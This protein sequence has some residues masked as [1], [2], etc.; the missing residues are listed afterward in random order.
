ME[1]GKRSSPAGSRD[2][3]SAN[4]FPSKPAAPAE[5]AQSSPGGGG[6]GGVKEHGN[7]VCFKVDGGGAEEPVVGFEDAEGPRRQYG[8]MQR[9]FTSMLQPGVNKFSLRMFGSQKAVEKEQERVKTAGFW[10]IHPYSDFRFYWDLIMLIM[11]VGN[12]VIIPVGIT[13]F[14]EQTTTPWIIFNVAS[15]TVFLLDLIMNFRT[16]TVNEDSSEIILD[17]K[18]IKMN[19]LK[20]W[21]VVDFIS[22]IPVDYIFLIV[23]KGM[24][25]E[26]YKTARAL[27]I[28]RFTKILSLLRLL[29]LSRLIRYIHQ[30]EEIFHMT[31]DLASAVVRIFNLIGMMLLLCHWDGCLQFLVPLLQDFPPD[32][33]V[34]LN[35]MVNDSWG[36]Q[37]SYALFKAMSHMLCIG[38]GARAPVSM[39]DL[40]I[41]MLSMIVGATCYAMFVGH[42]TALIQSLDSSRRQYQ[43]KYK[44]VEQYMSF[45][46]LPAEMRQK[47]HDYYE[48]RYQGKIFDEENILNELNDPLREE[49]VNFNCRKLVATMPLFANA[50]PNFVTAMLSKL[51]FEVFQP[52]DY[53][54]REGAV[55]KKMYF[56]QHG[57]AGVITKSNK[58]LKLTDGSYFGEICLL[59]KGRRTASVRADTYCRLYSLS[60]D[61]FNEVLEE[62]PMMRRAFET[63]AIDRLDRIGK[64]N[65]ILL[66]K[67]QKD[68]NT[69][70]FNN[71]ENEIL[72]QIVKHDREMVQ[73]IAPVSLQQMPALNSSTSASSSR[74]RTQSPPV[75]TASSLSHGNLHSPS[76]STQTPQQAVILSPCSY[77][78]AV[79]SPPIQS[80]LAGRTFQYA[81][82]T[83]SQLSLMQQ[84]PQA[85]QQPPRAT[86][87]NE[88]HKSTQALHN[89]TLTREVRPLS[90]SQPS[91]PH[92][93]STLIARPHPTVGES[94]ASLPQPTPGP[95]V[96]P[97]SRATVPQ[98]VSLFRQMSSGAIPPNR[99]AAP[100]PAPLQRDSSTVLSTEPEGDKPRFASN[101]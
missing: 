14:T 25:S 41:T 42:A 85:P 45:H 97:A 87:K 2:D 48:H 81:S 50:D 15:D 67:F 90:A 66:Q 96:P 99:G 37:Y 23:E 33:W 57:V 74:T 30:W 8:F 61:N 20:S 38:Y 78:T 3:G 64:K 76:P 72:K 89:T 68:L 94:L 26:V 62:Y 49:I 9:Q 21:F 71:Q 63:V 91:L 84:Q 60:V 19:Y 98:R 36:K 75:Y 10:I 24:D 31:Y 12:L 83:A 32:C 22:S 95:G 46:K 93:I 52:G 88:V 54:I 35:G 5:K 34:S 1:A 69:G 6:S 17:P 55:G 11:M 65:S 100:A 51:R 82:P 29:R 13:F 80:P 73:T 47:I 70:V 16:G 58:E 86:Q 92:E 79:C 56:I 101:L 40:W 53:I 28:V 27:R 4:A 59:T 39:S 77:T 7:S 44:Q 43:E 18:I